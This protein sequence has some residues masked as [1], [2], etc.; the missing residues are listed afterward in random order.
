M[1]N[2]YIKEILIKELLFPIIILQ[3]NKEIMNV[4]NNY[5]YNLN[6]IS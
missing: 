6:I 1:I 3:I 2:L 4:G 5:K